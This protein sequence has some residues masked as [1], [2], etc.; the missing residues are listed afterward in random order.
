M[1]APVHSQGLNTLNNANKVAVYWDFENLHKSLYKDGEAPA[2]SDFK[3]QEAMLDVDAVMDYVR[4]LGD[5][6]INRAYNHWETYRSYR[7]SLMKHAID[8]VQLY[9]LNASKNGADIRLALDA[10]EDAM[11]YPY[12]THLVILGCDSDYIA[13]A[14]KLRKFGKHVVGMGMENCTNRYWPLTCNTFIYYERLP[15]KRQHSPRERS[16][17]PEPSRTAPAAAPAPA[18]IPVSTAA[19]VPELATAPPVEE[20][21][22]TKPAPAKRTRRVA[23]AKAAPRKSRAKQTAVAPTLDANPV[24]PETPATAEA[25]ALDE[26]ERV[27]K[28]KLGSVLFAAAMRGLLTES[29]RSVGL[30]SVSMAIRR[31]DPEF[32]LPKYGYSIS[33]GF[34]AM[35]ED[36]EARHIVALRR[37]NGTIMGVTSGPVLDEMARL[38][39]DAG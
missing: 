7:E 24:D 6:V 8:L 37:E 28:R 20:P 11:T 23:P 38:F 4:S 29:R 15:G 3:T 13:L 26:Q 35:A 10:L 31:L 25:A 16:R 36:A 18:P 33:K 1:L 14:Q 22:V 39:P 32:S 17:H 12:L 30:Q 5:V 19:P 34:K 9:P 21:A 27:E 2:R